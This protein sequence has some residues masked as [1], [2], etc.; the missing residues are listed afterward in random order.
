MIKEYLI[1]LILLTILLGVICLLYATGILR[2]RVVITTIENLP[3]GLFK[4]NTAQIQEERVEMDIQ[5]NSKNNENIEND[6]KKEF[7]SESLEILRE[8]NIQ[9]IKNSCL[10]NEDIVY[11]TPLGKHYHKIQNCS[12]LLRSKVINSGSID[13]SGK[14]TGCHKCN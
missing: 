12:T 4:E 14:L 9:E 2:R 6:L 5:D 7:N 3:I 1:I 11:W 13:K 8:N 10:Y